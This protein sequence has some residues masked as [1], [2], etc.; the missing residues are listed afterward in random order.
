M[1]SRPESVPA[2]PRLVCFRLPPARQLLRRYQR[3]LGLPDAG[4]AVLALARAIASSPGWESAPAAVL[5]VRQH[6][7]PL[8]AVMGRF[9]ADAAAWIGL[10]ARALQA[11]CERL[12]YVGYAQ[13]EEDCDRLAARLVDRLG[14]DELRRAHFAAIPRGGFVPLG[15]LSVLLGLGSEQLEPPHPPASPVVVVDDCALSGAR[16]R[17]FLARHPA[18]RRIVF[19]HLYSHPELRAAIESA[20]PR[21]LACVSASDLTSGDDASKG[22]A[23]SRLAATRARALPHLPEAYWIGDVEPLGFPWGEPDRQLWHPTGERPLAAWRLVPP[24]LCLKNRRRQPIPI[25]I[26]PETEGSVKPGRDVIF[27]ELEGR[28]VLNHLGRG[29]SA[30]LDGVASDVWRA[31]VRHGAVPEAAAELSR[32]YGIPEQQA[33]R[34]TAGFVAELA[35]QDFLEVEAAALQPAGL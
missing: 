25:V 23:S 5:L 33:R 32:A 16:F 30:A 1:S 21:A 24:E 26:Q 15:L 11:R 8:L 12:C 7:E 22:E 3:A 27:G 35:D 31:V 18:H 20:E 34:E 4:T 10:E 13:I 28:V 9:D 14:R 29:K 17:R 2:A 19:A 6:P